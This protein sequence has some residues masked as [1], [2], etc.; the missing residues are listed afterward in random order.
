[1]RGA[2]RLDAQRRVR[3]VASPRRAATRSPPSRR[4]TGTSQSNR[5]NGVVIIARRHVVVDRHRVA[6]DRLRVQLGVAA[7]VERDP[8]ELLAA[9]CRTVEVRAARTS[10]SRSRP[11][12][13]ERQRPLHET[14]GLGTPPPPPPPPGIT[15][16][17]A[18]VALRGALPH[19][20]EAQHVVARPDPTA[21]HALITEPSWPD[22]SSPL[23]Y[24]PHVQAQ[25]VD[26][27]VRARAAETGGYRHRTRIRRQ[28]VDVVAW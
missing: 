8:R 1:M 17:A 24:Q 21:R 6:V 2:D 23:S 12:A 13:R 18:L 19:R 5:Q 22:V 10:R 11:T 26:H 28:P 4:R 7:R 15:A 16:G 3:Q 27:V 14:A 25:R 9:S 20:A